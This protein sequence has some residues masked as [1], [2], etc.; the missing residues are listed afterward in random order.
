MGLKVMR[1]FEAKTA[2]ATLI[3]GLLGSVFPNSEAHASD[4]GC[5]Q[6]G[7]WFTDG[8][9]VSVRGKGLYVERSTA[10]VLATAGYVSNWELRLTFFD[11]S[12]KQYAQYK[13]GYHS[14]RAKRDLYT[15]YPRRNFREGR[16]CA[17]VT[18][19][20]VARPGAC[21]NLFP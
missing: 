13:N 6:L 2:V 11:R 16:V 14:G 8:I 10:E 5:T 18:E 3:I 12:G 9:C 7:N 19:N 20:G 17:S 15:I 21:L 1:Y 4:R